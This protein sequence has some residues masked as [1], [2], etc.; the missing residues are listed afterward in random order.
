MLS[1]AYY[2]PIQEP[3]HPLNYGW[4]GCSGIASASQDTTSISSYEQ[5][6]RQ[7]AL[8]AIIGPGR[9]FSLRE[10]SSVR[11]FLETGGTVLLADDF[12]TGNS[13]L[14]ELGVAAK[15]SGKPL[16]DLLYYDKQW[17]F[18]LIADFSTNPVTQNVTTII[19]DSPSYLE[20]ENS[21]QLT[22]LAKSSTF[23]FVSMNRTGEPP[24]NVTLNSYP[25]IASTNIGAGML[26][27]ISD[28]GMFVNEIVDFY[29]NMHLFENLLA[30]GG[31]SLFLDLAHLSKAPLTDERIN[32][33]NAVDSVRNFI[34][35]SWLGMFVQSAVTMG[36]ILAVSIQ[37]I[38][39]TRRGQRRTTE[40]KPT[41]ARPS[42]WLF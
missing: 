36:I 9:E 13:L 21:S 1:V 26:V 31:G 25:V 4:N 11:H 16:A 20:L 15:F 22:I 30:I 33:R 35:Y 5:I 7:M 17:S 10:S 2:W 42:L 40:M 34:L 39:K 19:L 27:I 28:P 12:G 18:P 8:L 24:V 29:D 6:P 41:K 23:S 37:I 3:Y 38:R 32:L 14:Q